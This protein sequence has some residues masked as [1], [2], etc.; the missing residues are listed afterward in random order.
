MNYFLKQEHFLKFQNRS[1]G[2]DSCHLLRAVRLGFLFMWRYLV[3]GVSDLCKSSTTAT[4]AP[5]R[6]SL[7]ARARRLLGC[8]RQ[9]QVGSDIGATTTA[10]QPL[11]LATVVVV[12]WYRYLDIIFIMFGILCTSSELS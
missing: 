2:V 7:G 6:W 10:H 9:R 3:S 4:A 5:G 1:P 12:W 11:V 8:H